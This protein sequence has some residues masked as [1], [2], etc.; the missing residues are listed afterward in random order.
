M[1]LQRQRWGVDQVKV[2]KDTARLQVH[3]DIAIDFTDALE[4]AQVMQT[5]GGHRSIKGAIQLRQPVFNEE[6]R[7]AGLKACAV[8]GHDL[9]R[10][11]QY[12]GGTVLSNAGGVDAVVED[13]LYH[14]PITGADIQ[15]GDGGV[16]RKREQIA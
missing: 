15:D 4:I 1:L 16:C 3:A 2:Q 7:L 13:E 14:L 5:T 11:L 9:P 6:V 12:W 8:T 10:T